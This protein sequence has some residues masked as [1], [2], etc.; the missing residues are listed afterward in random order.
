MQFMFAIAEAADFHLPAVKF[1]L[2]DN[3]KPL[4]IE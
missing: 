3:A 4:V 2:A 1:S